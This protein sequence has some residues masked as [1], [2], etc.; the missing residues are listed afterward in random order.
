MKLYLLEP[1][2]AGGHGDNTVFEDLALGERQKVKYLHY[3]FSGWLGDEILE[4]FMAFIITENLVNTI[5][6]STL[7]G[8]IFENMEISINDLFRELYPNTKLPGFKRLIP[9]GYVEADDDNY[10]TWTGEDFCLSQKARLVVT[11][12]ALSLLKLHKM[13]YCDITELKSIK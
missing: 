4:T 11:E 10:K 6:K 2:V 5:K 13:D 3:E 7:N 12:K 1:E 8:Y 9:K